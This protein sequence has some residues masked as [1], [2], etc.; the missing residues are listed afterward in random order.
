[1]KQIIMEVF[2]VGII[3]LVIGTIISKIFQLLFKVDVPIMCKEWNKYHIMEI[4][5]FMTGVFV[6]IIC[7]VFGINKWYCKNG[8]ACA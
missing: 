8:Y 7:E 1:M 4:S 2:G 5:L 6:H 3:T